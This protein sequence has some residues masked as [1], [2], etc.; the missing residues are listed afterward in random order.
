MIMAEENNKE[1][2][3]KEHAGTFME[4]L[5]QASNEIDSIKSSFS[6][7]MEDL[8]KVQNVLS[9]DGVNKVNSMIQNFEDRLSDA[10]RLREEATEGARK[11]SEELEKEKERLVKLWDAY[12]N[13]EEGLSV[14]EK[15]VL[16]LEE[17]MRETEQ[18]KRQFEEDSIARIN[19]LTQKLEEREQEAQQLE[20][21]KQR[22]GEFDGIRNRLEESIQGL[23]SEINAKDE[24]IKSLETQ[25]E[26]LKPFEKFAEFKTKFEEI[27]EEYEK[28]KDRLTK[29]FRLYEETESENKKLK[30]EVNGWQSWFNSNEELFTKLF[31]SA[32]HLHKTKTNPT[33]KSKPVESKEP[34]KNL[35]QKEVK[36][37]PRRKLRFK[38]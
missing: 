5:Q 3:V 31:S 30:E 6:K 18:S 27:S 38:K 2:E 7:S 28:E 11:Y 33:P 32:D 29:L 34:P 37:K 35:E 24:T 10:E 19:T 14:Q 26:E 20:E 22:I 17:K 1:P 15:R 13:Q 12:K 23:K 25:V 36:K 9:L 16:E 21:T 8:A 4:R